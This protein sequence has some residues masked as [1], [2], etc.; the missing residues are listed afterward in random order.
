MAN[1]LKE[2]PFSAFAQWTKLNQYGMR[3]KRMQQQPP[4]STTVRYDHNGCEQK[5][6]IIMDDAGAGPQWPLRHTI[7]NFQQQCVERFNLKYDNKFTVFSRCLFGVG[8]AYWEEVLSEITG[9][10][11]E[12]F[13]QSLTL[14]VEKVAGVQNL[15]DSILQ[16]LSKW[17]KPCVLTLKEFV[18]RCDELL[19]LIHI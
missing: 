17:K 3:N 2:C 6:D 19:S 14:Y 5:C 13:V 8:S 7:P 1:L 4:K 15:Q 9:R 12:D 10:T 18:R 11:D 16:W